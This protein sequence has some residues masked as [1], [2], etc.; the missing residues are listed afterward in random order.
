MTEVNDVVADL[1]LEG[2]AF[3]GMLAG[4]DPADWARATPAPGWDVRHQVAHLTAT[5]RLAALS[6][7]APE[8][9]TAINDRL[10]PDFNANVE[11]A[12][13]EFLPLPPAELFARWQTEKAQA[14]GALDALERDRIVPWLVRPLPAGVLAAAGIMELFAHG[15][16][17]ADGIG[18]RRDHTDRIRHLVE[19]GIR[20]WDFGY[21]VRGETPP[22]AGFGYEL[23][24][25]SG[26]P[27]LLGD[28]DAEQVISGPAVDFCLLITRRRHRDD[29]DLTAKGADADRWLDVAQAYR[30]PAGPGR[31]PGQ[32]AAPATR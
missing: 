1:R 20:T 15:Q 5:F 32:F 16:D 10:S 7:S 18:V 26:Q 21:Q 22:A 9:F 17:I 23:T 12:L 11:Y 3:D 29:L 6:A 24:A 28:P 13:S 31:Q 14:E 4:L 19:F 25:P 2:E 8:R 30:G 27:W